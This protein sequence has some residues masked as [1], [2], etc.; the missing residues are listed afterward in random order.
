NVIN[1]F[2]SC[3]PLRELPAWERWSWGSRVWEVVPLQQPGHSFL[4]SPEMCDTSKG[5]QLLI[6]SYPHV[7]QRP[8]MTTEMGGNCAICQDTWDDVASTLPC[9]H[10]FCRGCILQ[11]AEI[12]PVCPLLHPE[13]TL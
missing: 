12:N 5:E 9:G 4:L 1:S 2:F 11:W 3:L 7:L 13:H 6:L 8:N 10:H